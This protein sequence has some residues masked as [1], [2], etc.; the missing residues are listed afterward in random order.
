MWRDT[1]C[2]QTAEVGGRVLPAAEYQLWR[3]EAEY[4]L[5]RCEEDDGAWQAVCVRAVHRAAGVSVRR[6]EGGVEH[7]LSLTGHQQP[8]EWRR[9]RRCRQW[10]VISTSCQSSSP[11]RASS[12]LSALITWFVENTAAVNICADHSI[13]VKESD[14]CSSLILTQR[15]NSVLINKSFCFNDKDL[16][17]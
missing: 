5:R 8:H 10:V 1:C 3:R 7:Q 17:L 6:G 13:A 12:W 4:Q 16:D 14:E 15:S 11:G 9:R 2:L